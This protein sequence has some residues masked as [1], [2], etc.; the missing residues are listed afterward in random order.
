MKAY[1]RSIISQPQQMISYDER[2]PAMKIRS[3]VL[4]KKHYSFV[5]TNQNFRK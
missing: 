3:V 5:T 2:Y 1:L 4:K